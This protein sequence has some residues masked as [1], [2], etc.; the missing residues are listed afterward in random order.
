MDIFIKNFFVHS[1]R[2]RLSADNFRNCP[3]SGENADNFGIWRTILEFDG[4]FFEFG[5]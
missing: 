1:N 4:Q 5:G 3:M 2:Q